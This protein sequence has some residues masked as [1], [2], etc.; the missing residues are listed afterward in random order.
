L[1]S[2][3]PRRG[4]LAR[5]VRDLDEQSPLS[6]DG[7]RP[8]LARHGV[9]D[10]AAARLAWATRIVDEYRSVVVFSELLRLLGEAEAP[11]EALCAVQRLVGDELRHTRLCAEMAGWLVAP[12][13]PAPDLDV[14][15]SD[16]GLP[17]SAEPPAARAL[18]IVVREL[19]V[20][21]TASVRILHAYRDAATDPAAR[22]ALQILLQDEARHAATGR[23]LESLLEASFPAAAIEPFRARRDETVA[24]DL[25]FI[26]A[27]YR[28]SATNGPGRALGASVRL[29]EIS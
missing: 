14:D 24:N 6:L 5:F 7:L 15:L 19:V 4:I 23:A 2:L 10:V 8:D 1:I 29:D 26:D 3:A 9:E 13:D 11:F 25:A 18:E 17:P 16:L 22:A 12:G 27:A 28:S 20:A 21:E